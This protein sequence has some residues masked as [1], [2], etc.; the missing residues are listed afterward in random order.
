MAK[1]SLLDKIKF[2]LAS[3]KTCI[4]DE[5]AAMGKGK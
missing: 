3:K 4:A 1:I 2:K 5:V